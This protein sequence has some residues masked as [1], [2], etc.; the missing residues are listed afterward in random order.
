M[1][2]AIT[3]KMEGF[4]EYVTFGDVVKTFNTKMEAQNFLAAEKRAYP[5]IKGW[6]IVRI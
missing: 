4:T 6:R 1:K 3:Y 5:D 2:F